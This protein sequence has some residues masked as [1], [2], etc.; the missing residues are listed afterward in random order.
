MP[1]QAYRQQ[2]PHSRPSPG[3][4]PQAPYDFR[5]RTVHWHV[6]PVQLLRLGCGRGS[7]KVCECGTRPVRSRTPPLLNPWRGI[8]ISDRILNSSPDHVIQSAVEMFMIQL[9]KETKETAHVTGKP[10]LVGNTQARV[11]LRATEEEIGDFSI[12]SHDVQGASQFSDHWPVG[13]DPF[14]SRV[15]AHLISDVQER[16]NNRDGSQ[17]LRY[18]ANSFPVHQDL[19]RPLRHAQ[20]HN[21]VSYCSGPNVP[22]QRRRLRLPQPYRRRS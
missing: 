7:E 10:H 4:L 11:P 13:G 12:L 17:R 18:G 3:H 1:I 14:L 20:N 8:K 5:S 19:P 16:K 2:S 9:L 21:Q 22:V 6:L 15:L